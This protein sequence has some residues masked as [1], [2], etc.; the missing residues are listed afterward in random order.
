MNRKVYQ[1][2]ASAFVARENCR[3]SGNEEWL[4]RHGETIR[5]LVDRF[6]PSGSGFDCGTKYDLD[7][8]KAERLV[9]HVDYHHMN[10]GGYYDGWT[11]HSVIVTPS[12]AHGFDMRITGRDRNDIKDY[13]GE[14]FSS[15][16]S[17]DITDESFKE[18]VAA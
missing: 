6:M 16:L 17:E 1:R 3:A 2:L 15:A 4:I 5:A 11:E 7:E 18:L 13:I 14:V 9:F 10:D 12:L 8:W